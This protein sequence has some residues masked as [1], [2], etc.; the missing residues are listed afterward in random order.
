LDAVPFTC[1]HGRILPFNTVQYTVSLERNRVFL[2]LN[3][4]LFVYRVQKGVHHGIE[5]AM[6]RLGKET[7]GPGGI[8]LNI[9]S[10]CGVTCSGSIPDS[11]RVPGRYSGLCNE[12]TTMYLAT[13]VSKII[14]SFSLFFQTII[15]GSVLGDKFTY[16]FQE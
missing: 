1:K 15:I 11:I 2:F 3:Q 12:N 13:S 10:T 6:K 9:S 8:V 14:L 4:N 5:T 7:G 16:M